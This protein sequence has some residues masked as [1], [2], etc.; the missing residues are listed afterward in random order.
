[1]YAEMTTRQIAQRI[2]VGNRT[3][4]RWLRA[5]GIELRKVGQAPRHAVLNDP[6]WLKKHYPDMS[7]QK[8]AK[9][10][11]VTPKTVVT[12]L[13]NAGIH[14]QTTN[15]G[16]KFP[17][18]GRQHSEWLKGRFVGDKNPNWRGGA[19]KAAHRARNS[20]EARTWSLKVKE[21]D[22]WKCVK[23]GSKDDLHAHHIIPWAKSKALRYDVSNGITLCIPC[24]QIE[25]R[26]GFAD[27]IGK[28]KTS[29]STVHPTG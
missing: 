5:F 4:C 7:A 28:G 21:R 11:G 9:M 26:H 19:V 23:C 29:T 16:R 3:I 17:E 18:V 15:K 24:H 22:C 25:H 10:I 13:K 12:A 2:G 27:W 1:M 6:L 20:K 14:V 8:I